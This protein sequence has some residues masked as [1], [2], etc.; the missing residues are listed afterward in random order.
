MISTHLDSMLQHF[1]LKNENLVWISEKLWCL[2]VNVL[3]SD[4]QHGGANVSRGVLSLQRRRVGVLALAVQIS[5]I[6]HINS[7]VG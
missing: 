6:F 7:P 3:D 2:V 1:V 4:L 5:S